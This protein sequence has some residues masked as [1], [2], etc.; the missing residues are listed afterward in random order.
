MPDSTAPA[1]RNREYSLSQLAEF[2]GATVRGDGR[3]TVRGLAPLGRALPHQLSFLA[4]PSYKK[5]LAST[6]AAAVVMR[7]QDSDGFIGNAL[8]TANPYLAY[9]K[10]SA[11]FSPQ[12]QVASVHPSAV[13]DS[14]AQLGTDVSVGANAVIEAGA[15]IGAGSQVGP[16]SVIGKNS[17]LG[18]GS[19][20]HANVTIYHGV[21]IGERA[22]IHSGVVVGSDGFGFAPDGNRWVKI[23]QLG[24]VVIGDDVEL[25]AATCIDRGALD[26]TVLGNGVKTDNLVHIAHNVRIGDNTILCGCSGVAGSTVVGANCVIGGAVGIIN[27]LTIVDGVTITA[28]TLVTKSIKTAGTYSSG[29][30]FMHNTEWRKN[31]AVFPRLYDIY[32][33]QKKFPVR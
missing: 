18:K 28:G 1:N 32:Q 9:A 15:L 11:L 5:Q 33:N 27:Q 6:Q 8:L 10:L 30:P 31:A 20:L 16:G 22:L 23:H 14:S 25:G 17:T 21:H 12:Q 3:V 19:T 4:N 26:D 2:V 29:T 13:I 7:E 24:G